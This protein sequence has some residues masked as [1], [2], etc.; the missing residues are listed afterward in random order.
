MYIY[1]KPEDY[2]IHLTKILILHCEGIV[3]KMIYE[4]RVN[5][6]VDD[7]SLSYAISHKYSESRTHAEAKG[8]YIHNFFCV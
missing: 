7:E 1:Q 6:S 3:E 4:R 5:E 8:F 2:T